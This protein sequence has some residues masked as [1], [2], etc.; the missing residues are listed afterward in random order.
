MLNNIFLITCDI[1]NG[2]VLK[3]LPQ[4]HHIRKKDAYLAYP[5]E[6]L[7]QKSPGLLKAIISSQEAV[8]LSHPSKDHFTEDFLYQN[9]KAL[10]IDDINLLV[11]PLPF[12][13]ILGLVFDKDTNPYDFR[14]ETNRLLTQYILEKYFQTPSHNNKTTLLLTL[15]VDL[16]K[17]ADE[18]LLFQSTGNEIHFYRGEPFVKAFVYGLDYAGKSSLMRLLST[19]KFDEDFFVPTKKFRITNIVLE[20]GIKLSAWDMPGQRVFREDWL[21]GAQASNLLI[22]LLDVEDKNRYAEAKKA[23]WDMLNLYELQNLPLFFLVNKIDLLTDPLNISEIEA[24]FKLSSISGRS[25]TVVPTSL[26]KRIGIQELLDRI[27]ETVDH[28]FLVNGL[29]NEREK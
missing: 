24:F 7:F 18:S 5:D 25:C 11:I 29:S 2:E 19:G 3:T 6:S 17:Y 20:S 1:Q 13:N 28:L 10:Q 23:F 15:F 8:L 22:F 16:R 14:N 21:R 9:M 27:G 4:T 26:P 12:N